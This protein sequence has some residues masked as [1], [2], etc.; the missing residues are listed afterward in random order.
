VDLKDVA[1][2]FKS[3]QAFVVAGFLNWAIPKNICFE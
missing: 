2:S 3:F 1:C